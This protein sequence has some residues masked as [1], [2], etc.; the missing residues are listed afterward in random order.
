LGD[1]EDV[2]K[3]CQEAIQ[4]SADGPDVP[5]YYPKPSYMAKEPVAFSDD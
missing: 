5:V 2:S 4:S 1:P 3:Y